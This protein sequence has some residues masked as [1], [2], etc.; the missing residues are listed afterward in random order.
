[1][2]MLD[3][4][5]RHRDWLKWSL[6]LVCVAFVLFYIPDF[7]RGSG[8]DAASGDTVA[9]VEG[10]EISGTD[11][12]RTYQAQLQAYR[13]AYGGNMND[14]LLKQ[15][16]VEQQILQQMVDERAALAEAER[17]GIKVSDEEVRQRIF[18]MPAFQ[19]NGG[20]IGETRYQ[21]LLRMQRPPMIASE[22]EANIRHGLAVEKLRGSLT[23]W[24]SVNDTDLEKEYRRRND[25]VKLA[26]VSFTA[27]SFRS[28]V[29]ASDAEV[30]T[31]FAGHQNDFKIP[32]KR[33][34]RYLLL[35]IEAL[36]AKTVV[37]A[38]DIERE[39]NNNSEQ[40]TTPEQ[41]RASHILLKTE[42]KD[43]PAVKAR[44]EAL[45]KQA[46]GGADF[47]E[48]AK[49]NSEDEASAKN[50]GDLDYFGRGR[51]VPEFD[52]A[53][54]AMQPGTISELV[55]TQYG[56]HIIK[57]VDKK[58]ATTR[59]LAEVRQQLNDQLA[60]QRAQAQA[61][62]LAQNLEKQIRTPADLDKVAKAQSLTVQESGFFARDEPILGLGPSP[63]AANKAFDMKTGEV[64][65]PLRASRGFVFETLVAKQDPYVPKV[66][67]VKDRVRD[68]VVKQK[69]RDLSKQKAVEIAA[70]LKSAP[71][72]EKAAKA[73]GVEAKTTDLISQDSPIPDLGVAPAVEDAAFKLALGAVSDP[74]ATDNGTAVIKV[75]EK[76]SVT[77]EEWTSSKDRFR[78]ELLTDR[79]N[80]FFS[81]YMVKAKQ[82]MKIEVNREALQRAAS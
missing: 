71:D 66:D 8:A 80:R 52:Q 54:F 30:A 31:Y 11:F 41:V 78:E 82:K 46:K 28:Q 43:D 65:G 62:D 56:Y 25:K 75:L 24:L 38:A 14:Q 13:S 34:M 4:M 36:R 22:F 18:A 72:F 77:A 50:G 32:E 9:K 39:Y 3:R 69:A 47:S 59:P 51:M 81:A 37:P 10:R 17:I 27:D 40:Y 20:F 68:E 1:M 12:R 21:Q 35:D 42:G 33:K 26:V 6:G 45:L 73:A 76:K 61:A 19:E 44:A 79:R 48:L 60:Y 7:L 63:E 70:K 64:S 2:T 49:K 53:V 58:N 16:G 74:I 57:L 55:K 29:S 5:R 23:D 15:L 67:E